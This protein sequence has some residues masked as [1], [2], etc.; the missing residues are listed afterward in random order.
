MAPTQRLN[1][2]TRPPI[3]LVE[4]AA[5]GVIERLWRLQP[6]IALEVVRR[7]GALFDIEREING[8]SAEERFATRC[9]KS[10]PLVKALD[11][12]MRAE[13]AKLSP[14]SAVAKAIDYMLTRW[15]AFSRFLDDGRICL[16]TDGVEKRK[17][18][19]CRGGTGR[20][21]VPGGLSFHAVTIR[22]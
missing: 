19:T 16:T 18:S 9:L 21:L 4:P 13:R 12:R 5:R 15:L 6:P 8:F 17:S 3:G 20:A 11:E 22:S 2:W 1:D 14:N 10:A 7:I